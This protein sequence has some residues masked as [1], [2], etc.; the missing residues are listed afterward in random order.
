MAKRIVGIRFDHVTSAEITGECRANRGVD[1]AWEEA[2]AR[3]RRE[4]E[5]VVA[6]WRDEPEQPTLWLMLDLERPLPRAMTD[7]EAQG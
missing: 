7:L 5:A 6:G 2:V 3:L 4:Y 1:G